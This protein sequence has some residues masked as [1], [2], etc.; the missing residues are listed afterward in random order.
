MLPLDPGHFFSRRIQKPTPDK[1]K[2]IEGIEIDVKIEE[3]R[4]T[5]LVGRHGKILFRNTTPIESSQWCSP[6]LLSGLAAQFCTTVAGLLPK[7]WINDVS[8]ALCEHHCAV[9]GGAKL[10]PELMRTMGDAQ[11]RGVMLIDRSENLMG[12]LL[13][14]VKLTHFLDTLIYVQTPSFDVAPIFSG[15]G[16]SAYLHAVTF[17]IQ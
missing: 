10:V 11:V 7:L 14:M 16:M 15:D 6:T 1:P 3:Q 4:P 17:A 2:S 12:G 9:S 13:G 8:V 5:E